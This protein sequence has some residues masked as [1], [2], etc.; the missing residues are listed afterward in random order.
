MTVIQFPFRPSDEAILSA[1]YKLQQ[2]HPG[3]TVELCRAD[4][5]GPYV[6]ASAHRGGRVLSAHWGPDGWAVV[7]HLLNILDKDRD[8]HS[9]LNRTMLVPQRP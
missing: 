1:V 9:V 3:W 5:G 2:R 6:V 8:L 4:D 7:D